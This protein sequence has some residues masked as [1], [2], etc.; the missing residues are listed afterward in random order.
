M[1]SAIEYYNQSTFNCATNGLIHLFYANNFNSFES[2]VSFY[3][4]KKGV[5]LHIC[6]ESKKNWF[7]A[8]HIW[9][10][11]FRAICIFDL[12]FGCLSGLFNVFFRRNQNNKNKNL[13]LFNF[14]FFISIFVQSN[15]FFV[16]F[17][18]LNKIDIL[19]KMVCVIAAVILISP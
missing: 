17:I 18:I 1:F 16:S 13:F 2:F 19:N 15:E 8:E 4:L 5:E 9:I 11:I 14:C 3:L 7:Y 6:N 12:I 10:G